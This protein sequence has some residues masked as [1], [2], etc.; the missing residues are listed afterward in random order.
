V[1]VRRVAPLER[2]HVRVYGKLRR[3]EGR[4]SFRG[5]SRYYHCPVCGRKT[6]VRYRHVDAFNPVPSAF[7]EELQRQFGEV[8]THDAVLDFHC[9]GCGR[10]VRLLYWTQERGMGGSWDAYVKCVLELEAWNEAERRRV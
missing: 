5:K 7:P 1:R 3:G 6:L 2:F 8:G 4:F 9:R 10:P